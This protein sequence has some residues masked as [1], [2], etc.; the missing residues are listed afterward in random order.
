[1]L[2]ISGEGVGDGDDKF[3][4]NASRMSISFPRFPFCIKESST[5]RFLVSFSKPGGISRGLFTATCA[6]EVSSATVFI[7]FLINPSVLPCSCPVSVDSASS[8]AVFSSSIGKVTKGNC[9]EKCHDTKDNL[10]Y[11]GQEPP[12]PLL[13]FIPFSINLNNNLTDLKSSPH[14]TLHCTYP[15]LTSLLF[16]YLSCFTM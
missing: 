16:R 13:R 5:L 9:K 4:C 6:L 8:P 1:M 10:L 2:Q 11:T 7:S 3:P 15:G 12:K 14:L